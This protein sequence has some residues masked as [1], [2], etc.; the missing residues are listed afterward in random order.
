M[1]SLRK[2]SKLKKSTR[3]HPHLFKPSASDQI[4]LRK[5]PQG[6]SNTKR[7]EPLSTEGIAPSS[8]HSSPSDGQKREKLKELIGR[9]SSLGKNSCYTFDEAIEKIAKKLDDAEESSIFSK[10][11]KYSPALAIFFK[12]FICKL[13]FQG[14]VDCGI[15]N[16]EGVISPL[17]DM[18]ICYENFHKRINNIANT[19]LEA[20]SIFHKRNDEHEDIEDIFKEFL[21]HLSINKKNDHGILFSL[22]GKDNPVTLGERMSVVSGENCVTHPVRIAEHGPDR[23]AQLTVLSGEKT[24]FYCKNCKNKI[25]ELPI[26]MDFCISFSPLLDTHDP[27]ILN[28]NET[29]PKNFSTLIGMAGGIFL[30][31]LASHGIVETKLFSIEKRRTVFE[32]YDDFVVAKYRDTL[33]YFNRFLLLQKKS[34]DLFL[35][36]FN[37][38]H[39]EN[40]YTNPSCPFIFKSKTNPKTS[41][42][43]IVN[44]KIDI[45]QKIF[46]SDDINKND[47]DRAIIEAELR[48]VREN[49]SMIHFYKE[50]SET[51][52]KKDN[53]TPAKFWE[54]FKYRIKIIMKKKEIHDY[55]VEKF[56]HDKS[57][58]E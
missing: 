3:K 20:I 16:S 50:Y 7:G 47:D 34:F 9:A 19:P 56:S 13:F 11:L 52:L 25:I 17:W 21:Q 24:L 36:S 27:S 44:Y 33:Q 35:D 12:L 4:E 48:R 38:D 41:K 39:I 2:K 23:H 28:L 45:L 18:N 46:S 32:C 1:K 42:T 8:D 6:I 40:Y 43:S 49:L 54:R 53:D 10:K 30:L 58:D 57:K 31:F 22:T 15:I 14:K 5:S 29:L 26:S 37:I 55:K 51:I